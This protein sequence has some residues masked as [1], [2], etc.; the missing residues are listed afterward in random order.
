MYTPRGYA[1]S[2]KQIHN[3]LHRL[4]GQLSSLDTAIAEG[5][6]CTEV[7]LQLLAAKGALD[8]T[9]QAYLE[10]SMDDCIHNADPAAL[11][12]VIKMF[13]KHVS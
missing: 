12:R 8:A 10:A 11:K 9:V 3:R 4:Q 5:A 6:A 2:M 1:T 7:I 13:I